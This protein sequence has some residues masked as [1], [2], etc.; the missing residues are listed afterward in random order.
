M[1]KPLTQFLLAA[2]LAAV[3][4]SLWAQSAV[5]PTRGQLLYTTHCIE[6]HTSKM[7]WRDNRLAS[8][9]PGLVAQ[10]RRWQDTAGLQWSERDINEVSHY[11]NDTIYR[12][13]ATTARLSR[14]A[15]RAAPAD[16]NTVAA[17]AR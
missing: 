9:W 17:A 12:Y 8:D 5:A 16:A 14:P 10:V 3:S 6:C 4:A 13:P 15:K 7:H 1:I 11:L 2:A